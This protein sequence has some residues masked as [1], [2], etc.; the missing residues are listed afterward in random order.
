M[1]VGINSRGSEGWLVRNRDI[2][3]RRGRETREG[4]RKEG[5]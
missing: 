2:N 5:G 3:E 4:E 1:A